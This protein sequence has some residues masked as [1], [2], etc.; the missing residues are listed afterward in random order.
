[1]K[2]SIVNIVR[3]FYGLEQLTGSLC[4]TL[5]ISEKVSKGLGFVVL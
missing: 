3:S 4:N 5:Y 1:M 2:Q